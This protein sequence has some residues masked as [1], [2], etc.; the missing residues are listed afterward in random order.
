MVPTV[1]HAPPSTR[2]CTSWAVYSLAY[3]LP[4]LMVTLFCVSAA[5]ATLADFGAAGV[6]AT[7]PEYWWLGA[8]PAPL[9]G[10]TRN[11]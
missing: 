5:R 9:C 7:V 1:V 4:G 10:S 2:L 8:L 11:W 6:V 3:E